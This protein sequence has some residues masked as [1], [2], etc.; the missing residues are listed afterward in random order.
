MEVI[1]VIEGII[2][3]FGLPVALVLGLSW[4]IYKIYTDTTKDSKEREEKLYA[5]IA[6]N[7]LINQ[8]AIE[9]IALYAEKLETIQEDVAEIKKD[10]IILTNK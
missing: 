5:E 7:R 9:T 6:E 4:F 8:K 2:A 10:M 1:T 3:N